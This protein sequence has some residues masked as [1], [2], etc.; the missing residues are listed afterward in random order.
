MEAEIMEM[1][2]REFERAVQEKQYNRLLATIKTMT[3]AIEKSDSSQKELCKVVSQT[4]VAIDA[5]I[6]K[7]SVMSSPSVNVEP[8]IVVNQ[9]QVVDELSKLSNDLR[10]VL[11][12]PK[13]EWVFNVV[14]NSLGNI[15]SVN[16]KQK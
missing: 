11:E 9:E 1:G 12:K 14:R 15:V 16:A 8:N 7:L 5:L 2:D 4:S 3:S 13:T 6:G 10:S